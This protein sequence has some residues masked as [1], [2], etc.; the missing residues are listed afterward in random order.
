[1]Y[2]KHQVVV[3]QISR[4]RSWLQE[5]Q[6]IRWQKVILNEIPTIW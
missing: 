5:V 2:D 3:Q 6:S 4:R 1:L